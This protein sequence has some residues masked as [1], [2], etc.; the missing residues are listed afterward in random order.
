MLK[1]LMSF[2]KTFGFIFFGLSILGWILTLVFPF[3]P[4][5]TSTKI[6]LA[7]ASLIV[8]ETSFIICMLLLGR[9]YGKKLRRMLVPGAH[10]PDKDK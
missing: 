1:T 10:K 3:T 2:K 6:F 8:A 5:E 9:E 4:L 7:T